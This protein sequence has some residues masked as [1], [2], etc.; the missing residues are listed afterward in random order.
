MKQVAVKLV[1]HKNWKGSTKSRLFMSGVSQRENV[2]CDSFC[3][4]ARKCV[5]NR[6]NECYGK[7][8]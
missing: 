4:Q 1:R 3:I 8:C 5:I 7:R 2:L 6:L